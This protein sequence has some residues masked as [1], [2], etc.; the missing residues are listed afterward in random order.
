MNDDLKRATAHGLFW[1]FF[2]RIGHQGIQFIIGII[3]ARLLL[4]EQFGLIAMLTIFMAVAQT[5]VVS[6]FGSALIQKQDANHLD[7]CSIF[8][9]NILVGFLAAGILFLSA[10]WIAA[11][12]QAPLL[13]SL[14]RVLSLNMIINAFGAI[15]ST[16]IVKRI[17]FKVLMKVTVIA[18]IISGS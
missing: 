8:F 15:Q 9:F 18:T 14:T 3:L 7:E 5:F 17:D 6:G 13:T 1:S 11:F 2:E 4:P 12:Y 10:P 16:L